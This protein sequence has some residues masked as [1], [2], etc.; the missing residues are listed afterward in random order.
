MYLHV[1]GIRLIRNLVLGL[2]KI[3]TL[4]EQYENL[5]SVEKKL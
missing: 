4:L 3:K 2:P 5:L 1:L